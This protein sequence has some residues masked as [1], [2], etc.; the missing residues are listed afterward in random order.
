MTTTDA[1]AERFSAGELVLIGDDTDEA[2]FLVTAADAITPAAL[3]ELSE[4]SR[5]AVVL[6]VSESVVE[7]LRLRAPGERPNGGETLRMTTPI[8]AAGRSGWSLSDRAHTI[9][10][11]ASAESRPEDLVVPGHVLTAQIEEHGSGVAAAA[12]ELARIAG[13]APAVT[14]SAVLNRC[15][16]V[17]RLSDATQEP[18]LS[19]LARASSAELRSHAIARGT[20]ELAADCELPTRDGRF[21]ALAFGPS[22]GAQATVAVVHGNLAAHPNPFVHVHVACRLGDVFGS[23]LCSCRAELDAAVAAIVAAGCGIV[24][25]AQSE[26]PEQMSCPRAQPVDMALVT[27]LLRAAGVRSLQPSPRVRELTDDLRGRGLGVAA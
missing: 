8:D 17:A 5:G 18:R 6:G 2:I 14:L 12:L 21:R 11:A 22:G 26:D 10:V 9:R 20:T 25:Y 4:L 1:A 19:R 27:G 13:H 3:G 23:L 7:R 24:V 16:A 15:G